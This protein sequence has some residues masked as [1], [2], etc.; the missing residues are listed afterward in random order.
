MEEQFCKM[1]VELSSYQIILFT[2]A[3]RPGKGV[4]HI[5]LRLKHPVQCAQLGSSE[6]KYILH[7]YGI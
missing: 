7:G 6:L 2:L 1:C 5:I 4:I 3:L